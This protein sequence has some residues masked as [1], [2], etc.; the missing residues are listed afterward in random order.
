MPRYLRFEKVS[1]TEPSIGC[2]TNQKK[3]L[4]PTKIQ[5]CPLRGCGLVICQLYIMTNTSQWY[6]TTWKF[7]PTQ[8]RVS[9]DFPTRSL[10][11]CRY[12]VCP[13]SFLPRHQ[14]P[15]KTPMANTILSSSNTKPLHPLPDLNLLCSNGVSAFPPRP[16]YSF[17]VGSFLCR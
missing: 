3:F 15:F 8:W 5:W 4:L 16:R 6:C 14:G 17:S 1:Q 10:V 11:T 12:H 9:T 2:P 13:V 7:T